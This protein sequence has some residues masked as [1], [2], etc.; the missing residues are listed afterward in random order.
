[1]YCPHCHNYTPD[2]SKYCVHC[3]S[4]LGTRS[5]TTYPSLNPTST[6]TATATDTDSRE[7]NGWVGFFSFLFPAVGLGFFI[8]WMK[9]RPRRSKV[10]GINALV[11]TI[12][13]VPLS[14]IILL[15]SIL[16]LESLFPEGYPPSTPPTSETPPSV[17]YPNFPHYPSYS[18]P[19]DKPDKL[20]D[21]D[22]YAK[23]VDSAD[24]VLTFDYFTS[25]ALYAYDENTNSIVEANTRNVKV[26]DATTK[27]IRFEYSYAMSVREISTYEGKLAVGFGGSAKQ[28]NVYDLSTGE[29]KTHTTKIGVYEMVLT[30]GM[31]VY[32]DD[33][34]WCSIYT[35]D[36]TS[37]TNILLHNSVYQ[38]S[39]AVNHKEKLV[40]A[41]ERNISSSKFLYID[42]ETKDVKNYADHGEYDSNG[43]IVYFDGVHV[44]AF[45]YT[46]Q[47]EQGVMVAG[48]GYVDPLGD[49]TM[50]LY[51]TLRRTND[52]AL[53]TTYDCKTVVYSYAQEKIVYT[54]DLYATEIVEAG[55]D[56]FFAVCGNSGYVAFIDLSSL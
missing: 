48:R 1:M 38:P 15:S 13:S 31:V 23:Y 53:I 20:E 17:E 56:Q 44:H 32:C 6:P 9:T 40:Y 7:G 28:I 37:G 34:Q 45:G 5:A 27:A 54:M 21:P 18:L 35:L 42:L 47:A 55:E 12:L 51:R 24:G 11:S 43:D 49:N 3:A 39:I 25:K 16:A 10:C 8:A 14:I 26:Y 19:T 36:Y 2:D 41:V 52:Y 22:V 4:Y 30:D 29:V 50:R 33:D 46:Y